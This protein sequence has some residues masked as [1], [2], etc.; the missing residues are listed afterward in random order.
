MND[1][2]ERIRQ[3]LTEQDQTEIDAMSQQAGLFE[4]IGLALSGRQAWF[5]YYM[6]GLGFATF[7]AWLWMTIQFFESTD[8]QSSLEWLFGIITCLTLFTIIK[9]VGWQQMQ[10]LELMREIKRLEMRMML[11]ANQQPQD[12]A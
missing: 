11:V 1:V 10:K 6:Y 2:D 7:F 3:A 9:V 12:E 4:M 5:T 8:I